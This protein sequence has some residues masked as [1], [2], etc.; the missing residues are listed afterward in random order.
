MSATR[1]PVGGTVAWRALAAAGVVGAVSVLS[2]AEQAVADAPKCGSTL[3]SWTGADDVAVYNGRLRTGEDDHVFHTVALVG[4]KATDRETV[5]DGTLASI[6]KGDYS[7][8]DVAATGKLYF[9]VED[10][11]APEDPVFEL[12]FLRP[13]CGGTDQVVSARL[14][15][16]GGKQLGTVYRVH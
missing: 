4:G 11:D 15:V 10:V 2:G 8:D 12:E 14:S 7:A 16:E 3:E 6:Y 5:D 9:E 1:K 13:D